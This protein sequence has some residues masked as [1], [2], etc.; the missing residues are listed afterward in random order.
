MG[1]AQVRVTVTLDLLRP[2]LS[3][4]LLFNYLWKWLLVLT[5]NLTDHLPLNLHDYVV[6]R[7]ELALGLLSLVMLF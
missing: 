6:L 3:L 1:V 4:L 2:L 5:I 7:I